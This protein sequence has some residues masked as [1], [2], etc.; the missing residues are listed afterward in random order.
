MGANRLVESASWGQTEPQPS[1][2][3]LS[4]PKGPAAGGTLIT[5][6]GTGFAHTTAVMFGS[7]GVPVEQIESSKVLTVRAPPETARTV[8]VRVRSI[9]G[10]SAVSSADHYKYGPPTIT[11]LSSSH[12]SPNGG[13]ILTVTGSGFGLVLRQRFS[14]SARLRPPRSTAEG[15]PP[16]SSRCRPAHR[17][18]RY[19]SRCERPPQP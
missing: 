7:T 6:S 9:Y 13:E 19:S 5:V 16:A 12:G 4:H 15:L 3:H 10:L 17:E 1:V 11:E 14:S 8:D 18:C 2:S